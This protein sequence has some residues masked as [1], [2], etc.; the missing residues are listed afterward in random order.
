MKQWIRK[1][2]IQ[3]IF[4]DT[5]AAVDCLPVMRKDIEVLRTHLSIIKQET[6]SPTFYD[7]SSGY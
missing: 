4:D 2:L 7:K 3:F 6:K 5:V 1:I